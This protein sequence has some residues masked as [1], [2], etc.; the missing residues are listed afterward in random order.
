M[1]ELS[2]ALIVS[3]ATLLAVILLIFIVSSMARRQVSHPE[4]LARVLQEKHLAMLKDLNA[5]LNALGDRLSA[6]QAELS[7]RLRNTV[8]QELIQTRTALATLQLKQAEELSANRETLTQRLAQMNTE[9][10]GKHDQLRT[11]VLTRILQTLAE[12]N[13]AEQELIQTTMRNATAQLAASMELLSKT[14]DTRLE[15]ISGRVSERLEEGFKKTN[16]TFASVMARLATIDE[17]QKKIDG[18][19]TNVVSLQ[20][21]LGDKRS[22]GAFGEVQLENLVRNIL[23]E[24]AYEFQY[25]FKSN[26]ARADCVLKLPEPTGMVAVDSKF[27]MENYH[28]MFEPG[29]SEADRAVAKRQFRADVKKHVEDI[30]S[31][32]IIAGETSD[33]AVMF[34]PAEAVFAEIHAYHAEVVDFA[35]QR[36]V[37]IVSPTTLMAVLNTARAVMKDVATR[38]QVHII[39]DELGKLGK[40][41]SRFDARMKKLADH[42]R[43]AHED[44][45]QVQISSDKIARRFSQIERVELDQLEQ[46]REFERALLDSPQEDES[47]TGE[48]RS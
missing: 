9:L 23:P 11:E 21:L 29:V 33:G 18:L 13:R 47:G 38:E 31:K 16:E 2:V 22:R 19:T 14:T 6:S 1:P 34:V 48:P 7:E 5:G 37:W 8:S 24:V 10:Q 30:A 44:A 25:T 39:K 41:F 42:I 36:R 27:P 20:E 28:R 17:A 46:V 12:Q 26:G 15:Q 4:S 35:M 32:Y 45:Q 40:D 43:Q 3:A